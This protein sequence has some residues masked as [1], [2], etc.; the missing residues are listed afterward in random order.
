M[1]RTLIYLKERGIV[2]YDE[3]AEKTLTVTSEYNGNQDRINE[4]NSWQKDIAEFQKKIGTY[5]KT[6]EKYSHYK[7]SKSISR[8]HGKN[9][10]KPNTPPPL[11]T[12]PNT[13]TSPSMKRRKAPITKLCLS[14][15]FTSK[16]Y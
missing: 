10:E 5:G 9:S 16:T 15:L 8:L 11:I 13:L 7:S 3:L 6:K 12:K 4:I 14:R 2:T 1:A